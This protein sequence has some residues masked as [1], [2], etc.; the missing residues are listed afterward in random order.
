MALAVLRLAGPG[1]D[2]SLAPFRS[3]MVSALKPLRTTN[4]SIFQTLVWLFRLMYIAPRGFLTLAFSPSSVTRTT[5]TSIWLVIIAATF[6]GPPI[7][8]VISGSIF[9][10]LK[11]PRSSATKY[12]SDELTGNTPTD[13][14]SWA[15]ASPDAATPRASTARAQIV[16]FSNFIVRSNYPPHMQFPVR[17]PASCSYSRQGTC[18]DH[19]PITLNR[20]MIS[21]LCLSMIFSENR[22][23]LFRIMLQFTRP[24]PQLR[25]PVR[26]RAGPGAWRR[27]TRTRRGRRSPAPPRRPPPPWH[28]GDDGRRNRRA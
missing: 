26:P 19:D 12:G 14:L 25:P 7:S 28:G 27:P 1:A 9:C 17:R 11:N 23:P 8:L 16:N 20:I 4:C 5:E 21:S 18:R 15:T 6:G 13:T 22:L 10:S 2:N 3:A 24:V